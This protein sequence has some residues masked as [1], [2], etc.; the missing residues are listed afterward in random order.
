MALKNRIMQLCMPDP[1][2]EVFRN[3]SGALSPWMWPLHASL[4]RFVN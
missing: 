2:L 4:D 3:A 1:V